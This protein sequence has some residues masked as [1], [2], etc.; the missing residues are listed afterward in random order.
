MQ[1]VSLYY[2]TIITDHYVII[3][4][5]SIFI[6]HCLSQ[7]QRLLGILIAQRISGLQHT[8]NPE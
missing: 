7:F 8:G 5:G 2:Y 4:T 6:H 3:T 1:R